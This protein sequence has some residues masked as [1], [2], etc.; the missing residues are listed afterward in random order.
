MKGS[1]KAHPIQGLIKYH[2]LKDEELRIP[3][4]DSISVAT[5]P[6]ESHTTIEFGNSDND[7]ATVDGRMLSGRERERVVFVVDEVRRRSGVKD[8]FRMESR[9]NF[10]SNVGLGASASG[11]AA[12]AIAACEATGLNLS[13]EQMS[14]I[15]RRGAGAATRSVTGAFA[16]WK[17]GHEDEDSYSYQLMS[18]DFQIGIVVALIP[19]FKFTE[20]AHRAVLGSPF[21]HSRLA[22]VHG[23]L[24]EMES[25][26]T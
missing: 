11:F 10:P 2:G 13:L 15:A 26:I 12:L 17:A 25:S 6:T 20:N 24:A 18:E 23:A 19:A 5:S 7:Q 21:F 9:N 3:F 22:Y 4:H 1:A 16:R 14:T 8:R